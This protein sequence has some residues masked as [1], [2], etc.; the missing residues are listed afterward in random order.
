MEKKNMVGS[1]DSGTTATHA[2]TIACG[3]ASS[4]D[5]VSSSIPRRRMIALHGKGGDGL[6]FERYMKPLV[7]ATSHQW[8]WEFLTGPHDDG[9]GS[10]GHVWW[11]L[12]P[13][14]RTFEARRAQITV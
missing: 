14:V 12:P 9:S 1:I 8:D 2:R 13:G 11:K 6:S 10:G 3:A 7:D 5:S 4:R